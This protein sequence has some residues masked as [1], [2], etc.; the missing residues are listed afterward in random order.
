MS[1]Y[2]KL[3]LLQDYIAEYGFINH[4]IV[5][6]KNEKTN[7]Y[8]ELKL[9]ISDPIHGDQKYI[10]TNGHG[11]SSKFFYKQFKTLEDLTSKYEIRTEGKSYL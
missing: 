5:Y 11:Y 10:L 1:K 7:K 3:P 4:I 6:L 2:Q 8:K 9:F